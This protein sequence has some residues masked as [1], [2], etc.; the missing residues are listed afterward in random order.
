MYPLGLYSPEVLL[1]IVFVSGLCLLLKEF[2]RSVLKIMK[3]IKIWDVILLAEFPDTTK[4]TSWAL[5][6]VCNQYTSRCVN[7]H[8]KQIDLRDKSRVEPCSFTFQRCFLLNPVYRG[9]MF[10]KAGEWK[11]RGDSR[12]SVSSMTI[13]KKFQLEIS[14]TLNYKV[15]ETIIATYRLRIYLF[16]RPKQLNIRPTTWKKNVNKWCK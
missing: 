6:T 13:L 1:V 10:K 15:A 8:S 7:K 9:Q 5:T 2:P 3:S 4:I 16:R 14:E 12:V 11:W